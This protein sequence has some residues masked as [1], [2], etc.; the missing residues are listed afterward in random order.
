MAAEE[1][2][3]KKGKA[4]KLL[5]NDDIMFMIARPSTTNLLCAG[6]FKGT[7]KREMVFSLIASYLG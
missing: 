6:A 3:V 4:L 7:V 2:E 1:T 5:S